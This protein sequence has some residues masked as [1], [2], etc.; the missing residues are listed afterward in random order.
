MEQMECKD[1]KNKDEDTSL[2]IK[3]YNDNVSSH[4]FR[5]NSIHRLKYTDKKINIRI[6]LSITCRIMTMT[7]P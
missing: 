3:Q 1:K 4:N 5:F 6:L 2:N 7:V